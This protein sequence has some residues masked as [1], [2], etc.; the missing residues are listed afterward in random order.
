MEVAVNVVNVPPAK[1]LV[2]PIPLMVPTVCVPPLTWKV[3]VTAEVDMA[4]A[5][6]IWPVEANSS[7]PLLMLVAPV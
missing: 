5:V 7:T 1:M 3:A 4:E 2:L 6:A